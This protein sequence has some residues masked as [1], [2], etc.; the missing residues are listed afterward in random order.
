MATDVI[1]RQRLA[2]VNPRRVERVADATLGALGRHDTNLSVAFVRDRV[3]RELNRKFRGSKRT[4]DVLSFA[5][6]EKNQSTGD[7]NFF[8]AGDGH[9]GDIVIST[10]TALRQAREAGHTFA[11]EVEELVIHGVLHLCGYDHETDNGQM[12]K[13]ELKLRKKLLGQT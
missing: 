10:D 11:R 8:R 9:I 3:M 13:L 4:T 12:N 1:N 2:G 7:V 6:E 5:A